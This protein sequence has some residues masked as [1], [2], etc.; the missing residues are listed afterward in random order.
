MTG[1]IFNIQRCS[2]HDGPGIRTTVFFAGCNLRCF[3]CHN[4]ECFDTE[5]KRE[6]DSADVIS[7]VK[8]DKVFYV[9]GGGMTLSGGEPLLQ[10]EF[11]A[12]LQRLAKENGIHTA[13]DTAGNVP[14]SRFELVLEYTDLFL[15][16]IKCLDNN[17]HIRAT[18][19]PNTLILENLTKLSLHN[20]DILIRIPVIPGFNDT[21]GHMREIAAFLTNLNRVPNVELLSFHKFGKGKYDSLGMD[22]AAAELVPPTEE[23][24]AELSSYFKTLQ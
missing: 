14:F 13:V 11:A 15:Y 7:T 4:P 8:R 9:D 1:K 16:D 5:G 12:E 18:G 20:V 22:Y 21:E 6:A 23:R 17:E 19:A 3:W 24:I 10:P 2:L